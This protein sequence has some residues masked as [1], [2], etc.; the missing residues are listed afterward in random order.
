MKRNIRKLLTIVAALVAIGLCLF[1]MYAS[2]LT[3]PNG[4]KV[5]IAVAV[6]ALFIAILFHENS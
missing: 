1:G 6:S 2:Y 4:W 3:Y 5:A